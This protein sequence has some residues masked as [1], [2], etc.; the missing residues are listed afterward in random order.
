MKWFLRILLFLLVLGVAA[1]AGYFFIEND[2]ER[3]S[4]F[5]FVPHDFVYLVES[6]RPIKDW[7]EMSGTE[8][9]QFIKGNEF[10]ADITESADYLDSLLQSNQTLVDLIDL[11]DMVISAHMISRED[12][13]FVIMVDLEGKG[14]K[15]AKLDF[16]VKQVLESIEY[17]VST[18]DYFAF[19]IYD[20]YDP[21]EKEHMYMSFVKN[22]LVFSYDK[23]LVQRAITQSEQESILEVPAFTQVKDQTDHD[24]LYNLYVNFATFKDLIGAYTTETPESMEGLED[25]LYYA[26]FD[27]GMEDAEVTLNGYLLP[28]DSAPSYFSVF[29]DVGQGKIGIHEILPPQTASYQSIGFDDFDDFID[30][31][32]GHMK[33][34]D[35]E[36]Y[37][38][39]MKDIN[40]LEKLLKIDFEEDFFS[41]MTEEVATGIVPLDQAGNEYAY[42]AF[43][44]F[45]DFDKTKERMDYVMERIRKRTPV[46][47]KTVDYR[48]FEINYLALKGFFKLFFKKLFNQIETPHFTYI[49]DYVVFSNDTTSLQLLIESF[50]SGQTLKQDLPYDRYMDAYQSKSNVFALTRNE[51]FYNYLGSGLDADARRELRKNKP[52]LLSFPF[53]GMQ[54]YPGGGMYK[55]K[56]HG[57]FEKVAEPVQ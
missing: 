42:Y 2:S 31:F 50:L 4:P 38:D 25:I 43:L 34:T 14:R 48:G 19:K 16:L 33:E 46:K 9:W 41:W 47:F 8:V 3:K 12:Y 13:D 44:H 28:I 5:E 45:D 53:F 37:E 26:G 39:F 7:Q 27:F 17:Q 10:F 23:N 40:R 54:I 36:G 1:Y 51:Y 30:R 22:I 24:K 11:G 56:I 35:P 52:Y 29:N 49:D 20:M 6:D 18:D 15:L 21:A 57:N 55:V 32:F